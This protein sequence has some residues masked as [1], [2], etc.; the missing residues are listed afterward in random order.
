MHLAQRLILSVLGTLVLGLLSN[1]A[2]AEQEAASK[3]A[4]HDDYAKAMSEAEQQGKMLFVLF[5]EPGDDRLSDVF[6]SRVLST[7]SIRRQLQDWVCVRLPR[8]VKIRV[9]GQETAVLDHAAFDRLNHGTGIA[10]LD[11]AN[12]GREYFGCVVSTFPFA[13]SKCYSAR[14]MAIIL[15]LPPGRPELRAEA[16]AARTKSKIAT[17][18]GL[19]AGDASAIGWM[20]DYAEAMRAAEQQNKMLFVYFCGGCGAEPCNRFKAETLDDARVQRKLK[21]YVCV[22]VPMDAKIT[23]DGKEVKL[24][25]HEAYRE[26][27]G[28]SGIAIVD[29]RSADTKLRGSVVSVFPITD[30]LWYTPERMA[31]IL[32]LPSGTLTQRTLIYAVRIHPDHPA[33]TDSEPLPYLFDEAQSHSQ[34]QADIRLQG[35][36]QWGT[37]FQR[38]VS[39]L[40]GGLSAKE[41]C[42]E[43][44]PGE[45]LVEAAIEC[46]RC[47]RLS[48]GHW[49]AVRAPNRFFA[50]DMKRGN[51]GIW[52]AT[53]IFGGR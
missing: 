14:Q 19:A 33:S 23:V 38:I 1:A 4:W 35:H 51:N 53:G 28:R 46:V 50:Y 10:I 47:W 36:H 32:E 9:G 25:E 34:H 8:D 3:I 30:Q 27:L 17:E 24:I 40:P 16:Y 20:T 22:Q 44:W 11:F 29:Y 31:V 13:K 18:P 48:D 42:A 45:N 15:D 26:M 37:R 49:S 41:V 5:R 2:V 39:R 6:E 12:K 43:S 21:E 7:E 52:Y